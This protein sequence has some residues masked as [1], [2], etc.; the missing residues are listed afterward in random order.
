MARKATAKNLEH[1]TQNRPLSYEER[2]A[3]H[4]PLIRAAKA[5]LD[6]AQTVA[7]SANSVYRSALKAAKKEGLNI[8][9]YIRVMNDQKREIDEVERDNRDYNAIAR[10]AGFPI[11]SQLGLFDVGVSVATMVDQDKIAEQQPQNGKGNGNAETFQ[12]GRPITTEAAIAAARTQGFDDGSEGKT[13]RNV[14]E[15]GSPE[16]LA[17]GAAYAEA[18]SKIAMSLAPKPKKGKKDDAPTAH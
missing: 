17:Y 4:D 3:K 12:E 9:A 16:A 2:F 10:L 13:A 8:D 14:Y 1:D 5:S 11:G 6:E 15:D 7:K 18:Q